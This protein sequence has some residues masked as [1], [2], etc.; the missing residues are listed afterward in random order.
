MSTT[1]MKSGLHRRHF[2]AG[3]I[4]ASA[5]TLTGCGADPEIQSRIVK[6]KTQNDAWAYYQKVYG[7]VENEQF[8][9]PAVDLRNLKTKYFRREV[10]NDTGIPAG[11]VVVNTKTFYLLCTQPDGRAMRYGVGLGRAGF[12]WSGSGVIQWKQRWPKWTPPS[13]MIARDPELEK[14]GRAHV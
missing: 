6:R 13:D 10:A 3:G 14:I 11:S 2:L 4:S 8:P 9:L 1:E 12:S 7:K 5:L